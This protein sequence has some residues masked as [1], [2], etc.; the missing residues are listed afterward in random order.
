MFWFQKEEKLTGKR[1]PDVV[2][3]RSDDTES[4]YVSDAALLSLAPIGQQ[5]NHINFLKAMLVSPG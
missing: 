5:D 1:G 2:L 4:I 3:D